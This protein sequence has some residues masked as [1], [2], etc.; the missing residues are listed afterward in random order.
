MYHLLSVGDR[1]EAQ[2]SPEKQEK[3]Q[4]FFPLELKISHFHLFSL[5]HTYYWK[6]YSGTSHRHCNIFQVKVV[7]GGGVSHALELFLKKSNN[8]MIHTMDQI[9]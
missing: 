4:F 9:G 6:Q 2:I 8:I 3:F 1:G 7:F 5:D